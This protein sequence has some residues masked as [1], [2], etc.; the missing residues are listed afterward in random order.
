[1]KSSPQPAAFGLW[2]GIILEGE[3]ASKHLYITSD[4]FDMNL[5]TIYSV[6][7]EVNS[8]AAAFSAS[9]LC[10]KRPECNKSAPSIASIQKKSLLV[11]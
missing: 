2:G 3:G 10:C 8:T 7:D 9:E 4:V 5:I 6:M 1:M 11:K